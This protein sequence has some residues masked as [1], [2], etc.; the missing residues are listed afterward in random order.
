MLR[1][2]RVRHRSTLN[3]SP[4]SFNSRILLTNICSIVHNVVVMLHRTILHINTGQFPALIEQKRTPELAGRPVIVADARANGIG[5]VVSA[6]REATL[7]GV[8]KGMIVR[9]ALRA[10]PEAVAVR[11]D[12]ASYAAAS[13]SVF[14]VLSTYSPLVEPEALGAAFIDV[15]GCR[16]LFGS[17]ANICAGVSDGVLG[18]VGVPVYIG[19]ATNKLVAKIASSLMR[20]FVSV[21]PGF[22]RGFL[23]G[24]DVGLLPSVTPRILKRLTGLGISRIGEL[25][26]ISEKLL[27]RQFGETG[28]RLGM[29][30]VGIDF[31]RVKNG[32]PPDTV[33]IE[34]V[35]EHA[36]DEPFAVE[37]CLGVV[38]CEACSRLRKRFVLASEV[39]LD[40]RVGSPRSI[41]RPSSARFKTPTDSP[42]TIL[43]TLRNLLYRQMNEGVEICGVR[44]L[45]SDLVRGD[46]SQLS[47]IGE[48]ERNQKIERTVDIIR[49]RFGDDA[50]GVASLVT[51][52]RERRK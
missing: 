20:P 16:R 42:Y 41:P 48:R 1:R 13:N 34:R 11:Y 46:C 47:L 15:T 40:I 14:D 10:C 39:T 18:A 44:V 51:C 25:A 9:R 21:R 7:S 33:T 49:E 32:Y 22:E 24:L 35:L 43:Q 52:L 8:R 38:A 31:A 3:C 23:A 17:L 19:C 27:V 2:D 45:F 4:T 30:A 6:S 50:I 5:V 28:I 36:V 37:E 26:A 12:R 29:E